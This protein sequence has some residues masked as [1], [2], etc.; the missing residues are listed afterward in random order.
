MKS[1]QK[2]SRLSAEEYL[3]LESAS[4]LRHEYVQGAIYAM[5]GATARH[6]LI[7]LALASQLREHLR[8]KNCQV[9]MSDMKVRV[10]PVF[11]YPDVM[12]VCAPVAPTS[13]F[14]DS[15]VFI[16]EVLSDS[17]EAKDRLEKLVAYQ[18]LPS[19]QEYMLLA[20]DQVRIDLYRRQE[21]HWQL[22]SVGR[23]DSLNLISLGYSGRAEKFYSETG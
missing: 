8:G 17:T 20:Q 5:V 14:Q 11:Y 3:A 23:G 19:L 21:Q 12:V 15:P 7:S 6:N 22:E 9:F 4:E 16:A 2:V 1:F 18:S 13:L 10:G